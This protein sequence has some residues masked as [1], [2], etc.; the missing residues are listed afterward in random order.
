MDVTLRPARPD[1]ADALADIHMTARATA[2]PWLPVLHDAA[3][4]RSWMRDVV[5]PAEWVLVARVDGRPR[6]FI[7]VDSEGEWV[8]QLYV[9]PAAQGMGIGTRLLDAAKEHSGGHLSLYVFTRNTRARQF[10]ERA[11][12]V[13][14][15][16]TDGADNEEREPDC[17][18]RW[19]RPHAP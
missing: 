13:L 6:G 3:E 17:I 9:E 15:E 5:L 11:G 19:E 12:F 14:V 7:A 16:Q 2:M 10:Y 4:T 18:Y 8:E 1:D